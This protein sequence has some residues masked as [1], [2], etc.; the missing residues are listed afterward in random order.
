MFVSQYFDTRRKK[1]TKIKFRLV[2]F[3]TY[4]LLIFI[5][6]YV[7]LVNHNNVIG[8]LTLIWHT[9]WTL[10]TGIEQD[11]RQL[12]AV[13]LVMTVFEPKPDLLMVVSPAELVFGNEFLE[14]LGP[15]RE[16]MGGESFECARATRRGPA[17]GSSAVIARLCFAPNVYPTRRTPA[18]DSNQ[19]LPS[20][21]SRLPKRSKT[22]STRPLQLPLL[23]PWIPGSLTFLHGLG[24]FYTNLF[25]VFI[26]FRTLFYFRETL[27]NAV[28]GSSLQFG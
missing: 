19:S 7:L 3:E 13:K 24:Y 5:S 8:T 23:K 14:V 20:P 1:S 10:R 18:S 2:S 15:Y 25:D 28:F 22:P 27:T 12:N 9:G 4:F 26:V 11:R 6:L 17:K 16:E 21:K